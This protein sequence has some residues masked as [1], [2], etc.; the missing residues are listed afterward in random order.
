MSRLRRLQQAKIDETVKALKSEASKFDYS[1]S[2]Y[3]HRVELDIEGI[4]HDLMA[5]SENDANRIYR[6]VY[7]LFK[8]LE[9]EFTYSIVSLK[10]EATKVNS[11]ASTPDLEAMFKEFMAKQGQVEKP[12]VR[13][14]R[15]KLRK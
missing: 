9:I 6:M 7:R 14:K 2:D 15:R 3:S 5:F 1:S 13:R 11:K 8:K 4:K 12:V 10:E